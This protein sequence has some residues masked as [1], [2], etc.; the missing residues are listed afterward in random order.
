[1]NF[2]LQ[3]QRILVT[4][5]TSGIGLDIAKALAELGANLV[6]IGRNRDILAE[7]EQSLGALTLAVDI[8]DACS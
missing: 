2:E 8:T 5:A 3:N 7:L 4:G 6:L 1:M